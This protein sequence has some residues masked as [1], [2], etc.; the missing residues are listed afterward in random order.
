MSNGVSEP[1]SSE[2]ENASQYTPQLISIQNLN[3][4]EREIKD[5]E[6]LN[7]KLEPI[8][9]TT[10][11]IKEIVSEHLDPVEGVKE[12]LEGLLSEKQKEYLC[13]D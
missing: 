6:S 9:E 10:A 2:T 8:F 11:N 13:L 4:A 7:L 3:T 1:L 5:R 12:L